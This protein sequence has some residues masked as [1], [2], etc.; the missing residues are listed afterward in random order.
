LESAG[1]ALAHEEA[2]LADCR[3]IVFDTSQSPEPEDFE[4]LRAWPE[5]I[6]VAHKADL[7]DAWGD[8]TPS[9]AWRVSSLTGSGVEALAEAIASN[10][11]P[12]VP[13][14]GTPIP[15]ARRQVE[16]LQ[17]AKTTLVGGH[18]ALCQAALDE[19]LS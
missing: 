13:E 10:L 18:L 19:I 1:I 3:L 9:R 6:V 4:L 15:M 17:R 5:A 14:A 16:L 7:V 2:A 12:R 11:V 8:R